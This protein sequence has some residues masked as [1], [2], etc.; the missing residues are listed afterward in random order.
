MIQQQAV[1]LT[2]DGHPDLP[3]RLNNLGLSFFRRFEHLDDL[4]DVDEAIT[5]QQ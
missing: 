2:G 5:V 4:A 1:R 3:I